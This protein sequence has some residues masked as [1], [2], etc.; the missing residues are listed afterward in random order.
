MPGAAGHSRGSLAARQTFRIMPELFIEV[1]DKF[2]S[3]N[4]YFF[5]IRIFHPPYAAPTSPPIS[6]QRLLFSSGRWG[7]IEVVCHIFM[8]HFLAATATSVRE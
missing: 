1:S 6:Q 4:P 7:R 5:I 8:S 2:I 3:Q